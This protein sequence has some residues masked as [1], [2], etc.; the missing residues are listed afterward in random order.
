MLFIPRRVVLLLIGLAAF[1]GIILMV[2]LRR[3]PPDIPIDATHVAAG[4]DAGECLSCHG[5]GRKNARPP[6]HPLGNDCW[7]CHFVVGEPR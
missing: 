3:Q 2:T 5:T 1:L 6:N 7:Q 4:R